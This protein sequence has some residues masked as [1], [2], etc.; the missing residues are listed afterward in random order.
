[1]P[2]NRDPNYVIFEYSCHEG[3]LALPNALRAGR[4]R[5]GTLPAPPQP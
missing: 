1:L 3:N 2:L 4:V 5:D